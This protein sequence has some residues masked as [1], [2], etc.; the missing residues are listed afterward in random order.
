MEWRE[1]EVDADVIA[2]V[3]RVCDDLVATLSAGLESIAAGVADLDGNVIAT[4][5]SFALDGRIEMETLAGVARRAMEDPDPLAP[6][7]SAPYRISS[8]GTDGDGIALEFCGSLDPHTSVWVRLA[9]NALL[10]I[11]VFDRRS[12]LGLVRLRGKKA[13]AEIDRMLW[14][15]SGDPTP[16]A[17]SSPPSSSGAA[18]QVDLSPAYWKPARR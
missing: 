8:R 10:L 2:G 17:P 4:A 15:D 5:G 1:R 11:V 18:A 6:E 16:G 9:G 13:A 12:S 7:E 3:A 14:P